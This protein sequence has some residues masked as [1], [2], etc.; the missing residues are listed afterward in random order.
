MAVPDEWQF[1]TEF[2]LQPFFRFLLLIQ[3]IS[4]MENDMFRRVIILILLVSL[5][6]SAMA[7]RVGESA[8]DRSLSE[9]FIGVAYSSSGDCAAAIPHFVKAKSLFRN[10]DIYLELS[11]C[12]SYQGTMEKAISTLE[13]GIRYFPRDGRLY[14]SKGELYYQLVRAGMPSDDLARQAYDNLLKGWQL[15]GDREAGAKAV[16]MA[17]ALKK[18]K[19]AAKLYESF[20]FEMRR[21]PQ[22]LAVMID[23]YGKTGEK[24]RLRKAVRMLANAGLK[25][26]DFLNHV[27]TRAISNGFYKEALKLMKQEI[28]LNP[29]SF[30]QWDTLMFV[31]LAA[32][33]CKTVRDVYRNHYKEHPTALSLYSMGS[34]L[35]RAHRYQDSAVY[36]KRA[37]SV[38]SNDWKGKIV[39]EVMRD[40][41]KVL[42]ASGNYRKAFS[43]AKKAILR[44][45][46]DKGL[47]SDLIYIA[48]L[49]KHIKFA[50]HVATELFGGENNS[51]PPILNRLK[52]NPSFLKSYFKGMVFYALE[53]YDRAF[54][55]L[56]RAHRME[57]D[58]R[59]VAV[60][61]AFIYDR[62]GKPDSVI[63]IYR[64]LL[65]VYPKD[66]LLLNNYSYSL[67][68]Y[69]RMLPEALRLAKIAVELAPDSAT[70]RDTLGYA[71]LLTGQLDEAEENLKFAYG[72]NPENG[73]ICQHLGEVYFRKGNFKKA[74]ELW[75]EAIENGGVDVASLRKKIS[76]LDR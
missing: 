61:L 25:N 60:P 35:G 27:A 74:R 18:P 31:A 52:K 64:E 51:R 32:S 28:H 16:E 58:N 26:S 3:V 72:K 2:G 63:S 30:S 75:L 17:F 4:E 34:C 9:Y 8:A 70:Y 59:D 68:I 1:L 5:A 33:D 15:A 41:L 46:G 39:I 7:Q 40:Y 50:V 11:D 45:P 62:K 76:F 49:D 19:E 43:E 69:H 38:D 6:G 66:P 57:P 37:L 13:E 14:A 20:P 67:L 65:K 24:N 29:E 47:K 44:F 22:L 55:Q 54:N 56:K 21:Q 71:Y 23:V 53:D 12:Y 42:V 36:F 48:V 10:P 73:E